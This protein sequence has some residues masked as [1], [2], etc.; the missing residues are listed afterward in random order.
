MVKRR[1]PEDLPAAEQLLHVHLRLSDCRS[2][3]YAYPKDLDWNEVAHYINNARISPEEPTE[4]EVKAR[5][6]GAEDLPTE[7][8]ASTSPQDPE[9]GSVNCPSCGRIVPKT[10]YCLRCGEPLEARQ[11][12]KAK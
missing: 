1:D 10:L 4:E 7:A 8:S 6:E 5:F 3:R 12:A 11:E 2:G 9:A